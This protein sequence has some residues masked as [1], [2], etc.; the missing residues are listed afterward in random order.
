M[1]RHEKKDLLLRILQD[2]NRNPHEKTLIVM[3]MKLQ[4]DFIALLLFDIG[5][6]STSIHGDRLQ[7]E[8]DEA[9]DDFNRGSKPILVATDAVVRG[10]DIKDVMHDEVEEYVHRIGLTGQAG[11][12]ARATSFFDTSVDSGIAQPLANILLDAGQMVPDWLG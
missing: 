11:N 9:L 3:K 1:G 2:I 10:L 6:P 8:Q 4:A 12:T 5:L 7:R